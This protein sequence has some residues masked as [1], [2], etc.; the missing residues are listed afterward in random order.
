VL[1]DY[2]PSKGALLSRQQLSSSW[3]ASSGAVIIVLEQTAKALSANDPFCRRIVWGRR[4][5]NHRSQ[6]HVVEVLMWAFT[7][8]VAVV[9]S[10]VFAQK[11][12]KVFFTKD[13]KM[14]QRFTTYA[15]DPALGMGVHL[16]SAWS[17]GYDL[18]AFGFEDAIEVRTELAVEIAD[19]V[20][21]FKGLLRGVLTEVIGLLGD[22]G[23]SRIGGKPG[24]VNAPAAD[25]EKEKYKTIDETAPGEDLLGEEIAAP[26]RGGMALDELVPSALSALGRGFD[27]FG[28]EDIA[29]GRQANG[30]QAELCQFAVD[31]FGAPVGF[32]GQAEDELTQVVGRARPPGPG[33]LGDRVFLSDPAEKG[34]RGDDG[35]EFTDCGA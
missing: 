15:L 13:D 20:R 23:L 6:R 8:Q 32:A 3:I 4:R 17:D 11:V 24:D 26:Q 1:R 19:Q 10:Q 33:G 7:A 30:G 14:V 12:A 31:A 27:A 22:P 5:G 28:P 9:M 25:M 21:G 35:N 18:D 16:W 34:P 2:G 29:D